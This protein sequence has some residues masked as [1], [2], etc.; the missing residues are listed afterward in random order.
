VIGIA[1]NDVTTTLYAR[2]QQ[3]KI[4]NQHAAETLPKDVYSDQETTGITR[5]R[6]NYD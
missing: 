4:F 6:K 3:L 1:V 2:V 5:V